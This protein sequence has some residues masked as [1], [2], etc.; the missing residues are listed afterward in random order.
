MPSEIETILK[1]EGRG[2]GRMTSISNSL[3][4]EICNTSYT[5]WKYYLQH[6]VLWSTIRRCFF[7]NSPEDY[8]F[9]S[10]EVQEKSYKKLLQL[11]FVKLDRK[12]MKG[13][14]TL[15]TEKI[16]FSW[17]INQKRSLTSSFIIFCNSG[18]QSL[19]WISLSLFL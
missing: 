19:N 13:R 17:E 6:V 8:L 3:I 15:K 10:R 1:A 5:I 11:N 14:R 12:F 4:F 7:Y 2:R 16:T 9:E 18:R